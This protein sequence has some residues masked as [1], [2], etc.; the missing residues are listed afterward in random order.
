MVIRTVRAEMKHAD[1]QTW[2]N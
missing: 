2:R 1:G